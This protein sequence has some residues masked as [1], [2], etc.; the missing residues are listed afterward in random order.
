MYNMNGYNKRKCITQKQNLFPLIDL[1]CC[2]LL[3]LYLKSLVCVSI[4]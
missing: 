1:V 2:Y 4:S 3:W